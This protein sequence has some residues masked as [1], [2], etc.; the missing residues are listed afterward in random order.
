MTASIRFRWSQVLSIFIHALLLQC[1]SSFLPNRF[2]SGTNVLGRR[3]ES[4]V[5]QSDT[6]SLAELGLTPRLLSIVEGLRALP[7]DKMRYKQILYLASK[8]ASMPEELKTEPNKVPGCLSTV[9]VHATMD[10]DGLMH[11]QGDSDAQLTKGLVALLIDG[12]SGYKPAEIHSVNPE[13]IKFAGLG[14]SLTP[15]YVYAPKKGFY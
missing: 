7:D 1:C 14:A 4:A 11:F 10:E 2:F 8:A 15:G 12:L 13:F 3:I 5:T 9:H 6:N